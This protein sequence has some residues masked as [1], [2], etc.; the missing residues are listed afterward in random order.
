MW[1]TKVLNTR[2]FKPRRGDIGIFVPALLSCECRPD[3]AQS[4]R[5]MIGILWE[6]DFWGSRPSLYHFAA[7]R[8]GILQRC[9]PCK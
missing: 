3:G 7:P 1:A 5:K 4:L 9:P 6:R 8:L 2:F